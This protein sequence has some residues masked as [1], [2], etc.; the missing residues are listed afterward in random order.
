MYS[1]ASWFLDRSSDCGTALKRTAIGYSG[2]VQQTNARGFCP[3]NTRE[4][5]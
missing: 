4:F 3:L 1:S 2:P 5:I